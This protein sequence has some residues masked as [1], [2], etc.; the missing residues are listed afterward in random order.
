M[1][2]NYVTTE[3][4]DSKTKKFL[5]RECFWGYDVTKE[6]ISRTKINMFLVGDGHTNMYA[7]NLLELDS[8]KRK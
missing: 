6:N 4:F 2:A 3:T 7:E 8:K 1:R 5:E